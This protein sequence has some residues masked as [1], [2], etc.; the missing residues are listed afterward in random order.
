MGE[1]PLHGAGSKRRRVLL[2]G[3]GNEFRTDDGL[4]VFVV[5]EVRRRGIGGIE[6]VEHT[7]EGASLMEAWKGA[8]VV[9]LV[10][11]VYSGAEPGIIHRIDVGKASLPKRVQPHSSH[12]FG[13]SEAIEMARELR[14]L[15][16]LTL[17]Y[18]IEGERF[19]NGVGLSDPVVRS[20]PELLTLLE[21]DVHAITTPAHQ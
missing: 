4:G 11:A 6:I 18:G 12:A 10:D 15:P 2:I 9:L 7:G 3:I 5:R 17:L 16:A 20:V 19:D 14:R 13:V 1:T 8:G 21:D